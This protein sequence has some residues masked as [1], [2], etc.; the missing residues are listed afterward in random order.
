M[1]L[2]F[3]FL[4]AEEHQSAQSSFPGKKINK[5]VMLTKREIKRRKSGLFFLFEYTIMAVA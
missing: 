4:F 1:I 2:F 5:C 3:F